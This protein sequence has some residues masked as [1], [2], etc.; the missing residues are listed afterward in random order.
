M[1]AVQ[2]FRW[3]RE[4]ALELGFKPPGGRRVANLCFDGSDPLVEVTVESRRLTFLRDTGSSHSAAWPKFAEQ[5]PALL[6]EARKG[7]QELVGLSGGGHRHPQIS[8]TRQNKK[9]GQSGCSIPP[10]QFG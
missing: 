7:S 9:G 10:F 2:T 5:F 8:P 6:R 3:N 4:H 1:L